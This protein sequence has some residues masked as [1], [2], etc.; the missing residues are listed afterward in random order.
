MGVRIPASEVRER[1]ADVVNDVAFR[2]ERVILHRHGKDVAALVSMEDL[3][4]L[5]AMEHAAD[6]TAARRARRQKAPR[7]SWDELKR[8]GS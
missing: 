2:G 4:A 8:G 3:A 5:E 7:V 1:L 6:R